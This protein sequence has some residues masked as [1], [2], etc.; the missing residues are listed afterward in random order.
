MARRRSARKRQSSRPAEPNARGG[1]SASRDRALIGS[2]LAVLAVLVAFGDDRHAGLI[3]DGRQMIRT[4]VAIAETGEIGQAVGRDFTIEREGGDAISRFGMATSLLQVPAAWLAPRVEAVAGPGS[5]QALFL[6]VPWVA[7]G[8]AAGAAGVIARRLGADDV[9]VI[10]AV[11]LASIASPLGSYAFLEL[12]EPVQASA[13]TLSLLAALVA[14]RSPVPLAGVELTAGFAAG[15]A[16]LAKSSLM[17]AAP[18]SLLPLLALD[19][20]PRTRGAML[21][22]GI[23]AAVPLGV[24]SAFEFIR[25]GR[26]FGGYPD[27]R[28]THPWFEGLWRLVLGPNRGILLFWPALVL[29]AFWGWRHLDRRALTNPAARAWIGA[30]LGFAAQLAVAAG[31]W[32]WHG[33]MGWGPRLFVAAIPP[34]APF[35]ALA[36]VPRAVLVGIVALCTLLNL[37]PLLQHP[38]PVA[39]YVMNLEWPEVEDAEA[40]RFPFY[41]TARSKS[42]RTTVVP[43]EVL[44][45]EPAANPWRLYLWFWRTSTLDGEELS[46]AL[47]RPPWIHEQPSLVPPQRWP[48]EVARDVS[49]PPRFGF[50]G[51]SLT[52]NGGPSALVYLHA[53]LDQVVRANQQGRIDRALEL[54]SKRLELR[55]DGE[56]AAWRLESL[57]RAGLATQAEALLRSL[58]ESTR[59]HP[60]INVVL[61]LFDREFGEEQRGRALLQSVADAFP[62]APIQQA[63][64]SPLAEWPS[65]LDAMTRMPRRDAAV[66]GARGSARQ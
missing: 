63:V 39:T 8:V 54:S 5:S 18:F 2:V 44:E 35:A 64:S 32:G 26:L 59:R 50:L 40:T 37:P 42:G 65:T 49:P 23:G 48:P 11:L 30:G 28:F 51:R 45:K 19:D 13:L 22:A 3:A 46:D 43:F 4:A 1:R 57:R 10:A 61:A 36:P 34:L 20:A 24:W 58:P 47:M 25:F 66:L 38:T 62:G 9:Q 29:V 6:L 27:D 7:I 56:A 15:V 53:L 52:G 14:A 55:A 16:V 17:V 21:R 41:S 33:M 31:Y 60:E 12:S